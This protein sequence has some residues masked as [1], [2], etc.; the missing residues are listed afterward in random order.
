VYQC[1]QHNGWVRLFPEIFLQTLIPAGWAVLY[2]YLKF[3][4]ANR[5]V[6]G[7]INLEHR[8]LELVVIHLPAQRVH[9]LP[10]F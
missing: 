7:R 1:R 10:E 6:A 8:F 2:L 3:G 5:A 9:Q 4:V